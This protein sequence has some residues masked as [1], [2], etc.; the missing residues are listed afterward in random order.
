M[1]S[2]SARISM[3]FLTPMIWAH[4]RCFL[5]KTDGTATLRSR[6]EHLLRHN[7]VI[8][9]ILLNLLISI[10]STSTPVIDLNAG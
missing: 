5:G 3:D 1:G 2:V 8:T 7:V 10:R 6:L 4:D 9:S